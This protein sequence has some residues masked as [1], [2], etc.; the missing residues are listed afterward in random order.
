M[1]EINVSIDDG[2]LSLL[3]AT[4]P[5]ETQDEARKELRSSSFFV[6]KIIKQDMPVDSG[7]ARASWGH[8]SPGDLTAKEAKDASE[9]DAIWEE[10]VDGMTITQGTNVPYV[11][12]LNEGHSTQMGA[13]FIDAAAQTG[14]FELIKGIERIL[15]KVFG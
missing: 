12:A 9:S 11:Q 3:L 5:K 10:G 15:G 4:A 6:E 7:R 2:G 8:W 13:G 14:A 1:A